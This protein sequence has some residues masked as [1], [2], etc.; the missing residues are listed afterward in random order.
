MRKVIAGFAIAGII[1][2]SFSSWAMAQAG[3][4]LD[5]TLYSK[6]NKDPSTGGPAPRHDVSGAWAGPLNLNIQRW[7]R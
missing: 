7:L 2:L 6:L 4:A 5:N 3:N 1:L